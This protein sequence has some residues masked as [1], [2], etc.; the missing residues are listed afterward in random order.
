[1]N[2]K[3]KKL[4]K[5]LEK[6]KKEHV[7]LSFEEI[8]FIIHKK[9]P[10]EALKP[11]WW[12]NRKDGEIA[13]YWLSKGYKSIKVKDTINKKS[14][15]F[16]KT[17]SA[18]ILVKENTISN[19][20]IRFFTDEKNPFRKKVMAVLGILAAILGIL[21]TVFAIINGINTFKNQNGVL[22]NKKFN[23]YYEFGEKHLKEHNY[24]EAKRNYELS[25]RT[26]DDLNIPYDIDSIKSFIRLAEINSEIGL[27]NDAFKYYIE[28]MSIIESLGVDKEIY[29]DI[30]IDIGYIYLQLTKFEKAEECFNEVI[31]IFDDDEISTFEGLISYTYSEH[32]MLIDPEEDFNELIKKVD[33]FEEKLINVDTER[34]RW[35]IKV[36]GLDASINM[37]RENYETAILR[38]KQ[39]LSFSDF[40]YA[41]N[42]VDNNLNSAI[43]YDSISM[44]YIHLGYTEKAKEYNQLAIDIF[45]N[46]YGKRN[47]DT[48]I[49]YCN[50]GKTCLDMNEYDAAYEYLNLSAEIIRDTIGENNELMAGIYNSIGLYFEYTADYEQAEEY[51]QKTIGIYD[52]L[53]IR[54][55]N[56]ATTYL[57]YSSCLINMNR[58]NEANENAE[59]AYLLLSILVD[60]DAKEYQLYEEIIDRLQSAT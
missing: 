35:Y 26:Y 60:K 58:L 16:E 36:V 27:Y 22:E 15:I 1:M 29:F 9:L 47:I 44:C 46:I 8:E 34:L 5:Y 18:N 24:N 33:I 30:Y 3:W 51:Y 52:S 40:L 23:D 31:N 10:E 6:S 53:D 41:C 49:S 37:F 57:N 50:F 19:Q 42:L 55:I 48:G 59:K 28:A 4:S 32:Y 56:L 2:N 43:A 11:E 14:I 17:K 38:Y 12:R 54:N 39:L 21:A 13:R 7:T 25:L 20:I 45:N